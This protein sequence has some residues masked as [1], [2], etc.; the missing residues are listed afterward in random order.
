MQTATTA[1]AACLVPK[2]QYWNYQVVSCNAHHVLKDLQGS[3]KLTILAIGRD[4]SSVGGG[5]GVSARPQ[6]A[7]IH[8]E[9]LLGLPTHVARNDDCVVGSDLRLYALQW[10]V[11]LLMSSH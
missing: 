5:C 1:V 9:S 6:H 3:V 11:M 2:Q 4:E 8:L 10:Q 7:L